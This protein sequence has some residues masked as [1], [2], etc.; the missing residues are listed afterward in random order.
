MNAFYLLVRGRFQL[1]I[2]VWFMQSI[3]RMI[4]KW[5]NLME[6]VGEIMKQMEFRKKWEEEK[7]ENDEEYGK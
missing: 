3:G 7:R 2:D 6:R 1:S 4:G 5:K